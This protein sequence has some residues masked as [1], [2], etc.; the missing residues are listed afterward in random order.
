M[1]FFMPTPSKKAKEMPN[2]DVHAKQLYTMFSCQTTLKKAKFMEF[3]LKSDGLA[4]LNIT[5]RVARFTFPKKQ[6]LL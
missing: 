1:F 2:Y 5:H 4:T 6:N 3:G